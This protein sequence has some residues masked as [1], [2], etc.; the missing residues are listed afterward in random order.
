MFEGLLVGCGFEE[1][2]GGLCKNTR[3]LQLTESIKDHLADC[4]SD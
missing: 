4:S 2:F 3:R 1:P